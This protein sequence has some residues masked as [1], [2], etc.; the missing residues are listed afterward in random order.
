[1]Q[2]KNTISNIYYPYI[3]TKLYKKTELYAIIIDM[4]EEIMQVI[5]ESL[6]NSNK[7]KH[8]FEY[9]KFSMELGQMYLKACTVCFIIEGVIK[10]S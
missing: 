9:E 6:D 3:E 4:N 2:Y 1:M 5:K 7:C 8:I 10:N